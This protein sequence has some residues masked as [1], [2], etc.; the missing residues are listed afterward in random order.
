ML[1]VRIS[2]ALFNPYKI[3]YEDKYLNN[4]PVLVL[5]S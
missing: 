4:V 3:F 5:K 1:T 2:L